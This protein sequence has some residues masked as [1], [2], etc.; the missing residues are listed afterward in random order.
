MLLPDLFATP[1]PRASASS[2]ICTAVALLPSFCQPKYQILPPVPHAH[3]H[4][5]LL[6][7]LFVNYDCDLESSNLFERMVNAI[8]R[9]AQNPMQVRVCGV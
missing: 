8:V 7:D 1:D 6:V 4:A 3:L 2:A 5:Q 9:V